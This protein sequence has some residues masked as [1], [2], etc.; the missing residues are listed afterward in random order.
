MFLFGII[1]YFVLH[2]SVPDFLVLAFLWL[3]VPVNICHITKTCPCNIYPLEP[4]FYIA[5]LGYAG[6]YLFF[7]FL[8][9]NIDCGNRLGEAVLT[10]TQNICFEQ[11]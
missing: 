9:Q 4:H 2:I 11:K 3:N 7:L 6:V 5:K 10:C 1:N 8:L